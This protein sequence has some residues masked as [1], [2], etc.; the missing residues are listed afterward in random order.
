MVFQPEDLAVDS[1]ARCEDPVSPDGPADIAYE[2]EC[3]VRC[4]DETVSLVGDN[5]K[6]SSVRGVRIKWGRAN[7]L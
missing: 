6:S 7:V 2:G 3:Q 5:V 4:I 1:A